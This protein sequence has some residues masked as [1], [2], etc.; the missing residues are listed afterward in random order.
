MTKCRPLYRRA[1]ERNALQNLIRAIQ[2]RDRE[3]A[4]IRIPRSLDGRMQGRLEINSL[5]YRITSTSVLSL[6]SYTSY[7]KFN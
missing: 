3:T 5:F 4:C 2:T 1:Q 6:Y 7:S